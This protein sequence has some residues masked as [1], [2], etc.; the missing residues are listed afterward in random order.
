[1]PE[2]AVGTTRLDMFECFE[3]QTDPLATRRFVAS[4]GASL[5]LLG[6]IAVGVVTLGPSSWW[7][8]S[9]SPRWT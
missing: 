2:H 4:T 3:R 8:S 6:L 7:R 9:G 1:M 5:A